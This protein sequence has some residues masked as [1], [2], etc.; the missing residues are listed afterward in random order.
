MCACTQLH[1][2]ARTHTHTFTRM[3]TTSLFELS[4]LETTQAFIN[5]TGLKVAT[6]N[7]MC[8]HTIEYYA[9]IKISKL[10]TT[11]WMNFTN[12]MLT[13]KSDIKECILLMHYECYALTHAKPQNK[14]NQ[15]K[16]WAVRR[17]INP[18]GKERRRGH[19]NWAW[20]A[21]AMSLLTWETVTQVYLFCNNSLKYRF[22]IYAFFR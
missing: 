2:R 10:H 7:G 21:L 17:V 4:K 16:V 19:N 3:L 22:M 8:G 15:S 13:E 1:A 6:Y 9:A 12:G 5:R 14:Q 20:R 18:C 11:T